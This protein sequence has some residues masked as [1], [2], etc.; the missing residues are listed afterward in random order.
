[1]WLGHVFVNTARLGYW[2]AKIK[3]LSKFDK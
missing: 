3:E 1:M 2:V